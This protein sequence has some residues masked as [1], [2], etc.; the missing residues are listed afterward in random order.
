MVE[1]DLKKMNKKKKI[2]KSQKQSQVI[3]CRHKKKNLFSRPTRALNSTVLSL[4]I[5]LQQDKN[6]ERDFEMRL[7]V[8]VG[9]NE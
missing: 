8:G 6:R 1:L 9:D 2:I 3:N 5:K 7:G 4:S